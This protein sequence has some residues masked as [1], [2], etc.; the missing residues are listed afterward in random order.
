MTHEELSHLPMTDVE[1][2]LKYH[3]LQFPELKDYI[4]TSEELSRYIKWLIKNF[5]R[6]ENKS[7][8]EAFLT[9]AD[10]HSEA[11]YL[12]TNHD[13]SVGQMLRYMPAHWHSNEFI[14]MY[15]VFSGNCPV[16]FKDEVVM[17][18]PGSV[19]IT[20][21]DILHATPCYADDSVL[22][23]YMVRAS[24]FEKVFWNQLPPENLMTLFFRQALNMSKG[25]SYI[26]FETGDDIEI[27]KLLCRVHEE[28][29]ENQTY[30]AQMMNAL[31][32]TFFILL[33]R[34]YEGTAKLPR[35]EDF[36][37]KHEFSAIFSYIQ[38][39]Y[40][41]VSQKEVAE[42]FHYSERQITRII[43]N[44]MGMNFSQLILKLKMEKAASLLL[45][46]ETSIEN[47]SQLVGYSTVSSFYRAFC[48]YY[49]CTPAEYKKTTSVS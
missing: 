42:K 47:I 41:D 10:V 17:L 9:N 48:K 33:L 24:T 1:T 2:A 20:A 5:G 26:H 34:R 45:S 44:C 31:F 32:S 19:L 4:L 49:G 36:H 28:Y 13:I 30:R 21:P 3:A 23:Y 40:K 12:L 18:K 37:W 22:F 35:T 11:T 39:H 25:T 6:E 27:K 29:Q 38:I 15:Y 16:Y 14:E 46:E 8:R 7:A 43:E